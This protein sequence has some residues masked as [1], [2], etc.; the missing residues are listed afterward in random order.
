MCVCVCV[1]VCVR[2]GGG[3]ECTLVT[4]YLD[5][6][7]VVW[8]AVYKAPT[9]PFNLRWTVSC[10]HKKLLAFQNDF[11]YRT[12]TWGYARRVRDMAIQLLPCTA[13]YN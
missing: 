4:E 12:L 1:C 5:Q 13:T 10:P 8:L 11:Y 6:W 3:E 2:D 9:P 7:L